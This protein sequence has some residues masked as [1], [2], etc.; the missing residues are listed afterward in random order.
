MKIIL[1][2]ALLISLCVES[3][4]QKRGGR[5][6]ETMNILINPDEDKDYKVDTSELR[7]W[8]EAVEKVFERNKIGM[9]MPML[10]ID[11][12]KKFDE[13]LDRELSSREERNLRD[14]MKKLFAD[15]SKRLITEYDA[16]KNRRLDTKELITLREAIPN[17][18]NYAL[19]P[20]EVKPVKD[21]KLAVKPK[22]PEVIKQRK[23]DDIYD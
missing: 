13:D 7:D 15:A 8:L 21:L 11:I 17:F 14:H 23:L 19:K 20:V 6:L 16:N 22:T 10:N 3:F 18:Y 4:A 9:K 12:V 5:S 1:A 2:A